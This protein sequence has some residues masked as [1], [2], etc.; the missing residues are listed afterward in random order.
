MDRRGRGSLIKALRNLSAN[1]SQTS[2]W[3]IGL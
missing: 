3:R 1:G 2:P